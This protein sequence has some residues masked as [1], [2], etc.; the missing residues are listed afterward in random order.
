MTRQWADQLP[1]VGFLYV[2]H[3]DRCGRREIPYGAPLAC[4]LGQ[5]ALLR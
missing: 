2:W 5:M 3:H 1:T 4:H